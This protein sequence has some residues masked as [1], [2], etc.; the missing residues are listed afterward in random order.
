M[1][2]AAIQFIIASSFALGPM[3]AQKGIAGVASTAIRETTEVVIR[4]FGK[5]VAGESTE[6]VSKRIAEVGAKFGAEGLEAMGKVGPRAFGKIT[7]EAGEYASQAVKLTAKYG[8]EAVWVISKPRGLAVFV[9]HGEEAAT[10]VMKHP[11]VAEGAVERLGI[12]AARALNS[13]SG[14][15]A[16]RL[17]MMIEDG[18]I[19]TGERSAG[20]LDVVAKYGDKA[21]EF[22]WKNK[23]ALAVAAGLTAFLHDPEPF[24]QGTKDLVVEA[25]KPIGTEVTRRTNWTPVMIAGLAGCAGLLAL[26]MWMRKRQSATNAPRS[27]ATGQEPTP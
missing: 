5:E 20:L 13:V 25:V 22:I 10:A 7:I 16:R 6:A 4:K 18:A 26:R 27:K 21:M 23:G 1:R 19:K 11:G 17:G 3:L 8:D 12:P 2:R 24:I 15:E 9:K 14:A